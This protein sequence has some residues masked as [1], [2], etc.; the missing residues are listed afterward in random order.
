MGRFFIL[1]TFLPV[2]AFANSDL[3]GLWTSTTG[4]LCASTGEVSPSWARL[5]LAQ[6]NSYKQSIHFGFPGHSCRKDVSGGYQI[7]GRKISFGPSV[8][9]T[10]CGGSPTSGKSEIPQYEVSYEASGDELRITLKDQL[11]ESL[12]TTFRKVQ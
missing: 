9:S 4:V 8:L 3:T 6:D 2:F 12:I 5:N 11:C 10:E 7:Q 1:L